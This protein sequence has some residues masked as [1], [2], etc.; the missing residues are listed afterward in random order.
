[1]IGGS[2]LLD[3]TAN[4]RPPYLAGLEWWDS[5]NKIKDNRDKIRSSTFEV[6]GGEIFLLLQ[7]SWHLGR[8]LDCRNCQV[9]HIQWPGWGL[10]EWW[11]DRGVTVVQ[12]S[13]T[14]L[15]IH[16][17]HLEACYMMSPALRNHLLEFA[18]QL[19]TKTLNLLCDFGFSWSTVRLPYWDFTGQSHLQ[20]GWWC[21]LCALAALHAFS[22]QAL[23][24]FHL[25]FMYL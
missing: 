23:Q 2:I 1:M 25:V 3:L 4:P 11:W 14:H 12:R 24:F 20:V 22:S 9:K 8:I 6:A 5:F 21:L 7:K 19:S 10:G 18:Y 15:L 16:K 13:V 17:L